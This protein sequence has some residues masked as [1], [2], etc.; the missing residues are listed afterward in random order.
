M[1]DNVVV[2]RPEL[3]GDG[4][5]VDADRVLTSPAGSLE[6]AVVI[7]RDKDGELYFASSEGSPQTLWLIEQAKRLLLDT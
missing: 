3:V 7:G 6:Q 2:F 4:A 1:G 5:R